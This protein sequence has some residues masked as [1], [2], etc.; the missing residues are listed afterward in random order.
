[1][2]RTPVRHEQCFC[3]KQHFSLVLCCHYRWYHNTF[4][5]LFVRLWYAQEEKNKQAEVLL[6]KLSKHFSLH[7]SVFLPFLFPHSTASAVF[8]NW[9]CYF[10]KCHAVH[11]YCPAGRKEA[12]YC[13]SVPSTIT[14][15]HVSFHVCDAHV[16]S[17]TFTCL[18]SYDG[19]QTTS[20]Q[21]LGVDVPQ[22]QCDIFGHPLGHFSN[23]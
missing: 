7:N 1:M 3:W 14:C 5:F 23:P 9:P 21:C 16:T 11:G 2:L 12:A 8:E 13:A 20:T 19:T 10:L 4:V 18:L 15:F 17:S 22:S 6:Y